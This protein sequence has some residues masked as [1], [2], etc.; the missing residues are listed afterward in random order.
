MVQSFD[1]PRIDTFSLNEVL[2]YL[3][4]CSFATLLEGYRGHSFGKM[5]L[6][7]EVTGSESEVRKSCIYAGLQESI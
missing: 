7:I 4:S 1:H 3:L 2:F 5:F 6:N